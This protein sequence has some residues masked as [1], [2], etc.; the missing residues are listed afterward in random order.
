ML[1]IDR[2]G[3]FALLATGCD[4]VHVHDT[5][6][7]K[8]STASA[9]DILDLMECNNVTVTNL[10]SKMSTDDIVKPGSDCALGFTRPAR[11][12][13]IRN[14]IGDT[15]CNLFQIGSETADD[16][17]DVYV[18][19]IYILGGNKAGFSISTNDGAHVKNVYLNSGY[20]G[21]I[22]SRSVMKRTRA[23]FFISISNRGRV[24]GAD[25]KRFSFVEN[26]VTRNELLCTN[27]NIGRVENIIINGVD[28]SE[29]YA[30]TSFR[31][32]RWKPYD[33]TQNKSTPI[34]AGY[35]LP[36]SENVEGGL[37]FSLPDGRHTGYITNIQ[38][39]DVNLLVKGG[40]PIEDADAYPPELG[41]GRY[42]VGD[43]RTQPSYGYWVRHAKDFLLKD[44][45]V[46][47][48]T[49][50][51]RHVVVLEN[52]TGAVIENLQIPEDD[53][54]PVPVKE[55]NSRNVRITIK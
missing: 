43:L 49:K 11:N 26:G 28:I 5:Y 1:S 27:V 18:D 41:V 30:G 16:I 21:T 20:T 12:F 19:N 53:K 35:S 36:K 25:V 47:Y 8:A 45:T 42:N 24:I 48:E 13:K 46:A 32:E 3:H 44:C 38:F 2:G 9:R 37:N 17:Q 22:H 54:Q 10:Y 40:N 52:V 55:I 50:D 29:V 34:I 6:F 4:D 51:E 23:P 15:N 31:S 14:I 7:G 39:H 33:G